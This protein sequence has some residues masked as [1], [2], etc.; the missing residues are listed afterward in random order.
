M[1][2]H[3]FFDGVRWSYYNELFNDLVD[4]VTTMSCLTI[5]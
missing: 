5:S 1:F 3:L 2:T 4:G